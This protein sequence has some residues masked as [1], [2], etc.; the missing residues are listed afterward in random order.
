MESSSPQ[1]SPDHDPLD[2]ATDA[3]DAKGPVVAAAT[4][5]DR[6][7]LLALAGQVQDDV[8]VAG[9]HEEEGAETPAANLK[10]LFWRRIRIPAALFI[11]T[12]G[13]TFIAGATRWMPDRVL[14]SLGTDEFIAPMSSL[15]LRRS[16]YTNFHEAMIYM[17]CVLAILLAHEMGHFIATLIHRVRATLPFFIPFPLSP[18]GTMGAVIGME[19]H[20]ADRCQMFDIGL[21]G[22]LAGLV[23][24]VPILWMGILNLDLAQP[25]DGTRRFDLPIAV[26]YLI[27][28]AHPGKLQGHEISVAQVNGWFMAAWVG[29]LVTGLNMMPVSQLDG[30]HVT[31]ALFGKYAHWIARGFMVFVFAYFAYTLDFSLSLMAV[32]VLLLGTDHPPTRD[33]SRPLGWVR[34]LIGFCSLIIPWITFAPGLFSP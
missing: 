18:T 2:P 3:R 4:G 26:R 12:C 1:T 34:T 29:L 23:V 5:A 25:L 33:D 24:A 31:Y 11:L 20:K 15:I 32:L 7:P 6:S 13:S 14:Q 8:A 30:G 21:A 10:R 22:P 16:V 28:V 27:E 9:E 19:A 17:G